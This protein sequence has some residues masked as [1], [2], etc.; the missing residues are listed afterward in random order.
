MEEYE[1]CEL[2]IELTEDQ[3]SRVDDLFGIVVSIDIECRDH[4]SRLLWSACSRAGVKEISREER[5]KLFDE[6]RQMNASPGQCCAIFNIDMDGYSE[7]VE[8]YKRAKAIQRLKS[9]PYSEYLNTPHWRKVRDSILERDAGKCKLCNSDQQL[10]VHHR[11]YQ[12]LGEEIPEDLITL[13]ASCH[14][15]FHGNGVLVRSTA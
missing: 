2:E 5:L 1:D 7:I 3:S 8:E 10:H 4:Q 13:C 11:T 12:R 15:T 9:L 6:I 14:R